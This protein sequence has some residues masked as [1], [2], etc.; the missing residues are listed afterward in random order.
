MS[1]KASI[2]VPSRGVDVRLSVE[3]G[4]VLALLG[5]NGSGKT[6]VL[7]VLAGLLRTANGTVLLA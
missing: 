4:G 3:S 2:H 7:E 5:T 6:T 1:L